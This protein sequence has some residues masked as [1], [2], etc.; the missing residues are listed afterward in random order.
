MQK[1]AI[2]DTIL[3]KII[4]VIVILLLFAIVVYFLKKGVGGMFKF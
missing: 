3:E 1:R 2:F 4:L